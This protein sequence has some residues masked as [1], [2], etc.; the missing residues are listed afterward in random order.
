MGWRSSRRFCA[1]VRS[2]RE[3]D[4]FCL[5]RRH[6]RTCSG[7]PRLCFGAAFKTWI[8]RRGHDDSIKSHPALASPRAS[9]SGRGDRRK[10]G[11]GQTN[12][13][14]PIGAVDRRDALRARRDH[15]C[16]VKA[17][18]AG[19]SE[20]R[21]VPGAHRAAPAPAPLPEIITEMRLR[22]VNAVRTM[23]GDAM[24][25][26]ELGH[27]QF[28]GTR[29]IRHEQQGGCEEKTPDHDVTKMQK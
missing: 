19:E 17:G 21:A 25:L 1:T 6:G 24:H 26:M 10:N 15:R 2:A 3:Y 11:L 5:M 29:A 22:R 23:H 18:R 20:R 7:H 9:P 28:G 14:A 16:S 12:I 27:R 4:D 13:G 8:A